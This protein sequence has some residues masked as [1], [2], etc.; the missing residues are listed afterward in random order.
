MMSRKHVLALNSSAE[1]REKIMKAL[2]Y[3]AKLF[4]ALGAGDA[5]TKSLA[6][7]FSACRRLVTFLRWVKYSDNFIEAAATPAKPLRGL[8]YAE[9][10]LNVTVDCMCDVITL[11]QLGLLGRVR[12]PAVL[13]MSF[14]RLTDVL[15]ALLAAI[16]VTAAILKLRAAAA[17]Q[18]LTRRLELVGYIG[19]LLK[20]VHNAELDFGG[21]VPGATLAAV[22]G[23]TAAALSARKIKLKLAPASE[24][25]SLKQR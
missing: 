11:K 8:L 1:F 25:M 12:L 20:N 24:G 21:V 16:G 14:E 15:D 9:A 7:H 10:S 4:V 5:A 3:L 13:G 18:T 19:D 2:Q 22:G 23:L 6:K 17:S